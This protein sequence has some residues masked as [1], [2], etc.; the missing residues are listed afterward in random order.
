[1]GG[2]GRGREGGAARLPRGGGREGG[3]GAAAA[4]SEA[5]RGHGFGRGF[6]GCTGS[7]GVE[8][9][10]RLWMRQLGSRR[11]ARR[12]MARGRGADRAAALRAADAVGLSG[13]G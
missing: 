11:C 4:S 10:V 5:S 3:G 13:F 2:E 1:R 8:G 9:A 7:R 6:V 12:A